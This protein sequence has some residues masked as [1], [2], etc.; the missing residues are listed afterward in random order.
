[1]GRFLQVQAQGLLPG[2]L[3]SEARLHDAPQSQSS[4]E[5]G[6]LAPQPTF[7]LKSKAVRL[8]AS[9]QSA[10]A[11]IRAENTKSE[12]GMAGAVQE[13]PGWSRAPAIPAA[14]L[15]PSPYGLQ[16]DTVCL[17][18]WHRVLC[19]EHCC[20]P[21]S[22]HRRVERATAAKERELRCGS[23]VEGEAWGVLEGVSIIVV[24]QRCSQA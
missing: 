22:S 2:L 3:G 6:R 17:H 19:M 7:V 24:Q 15:H 16:L 23:T 18:S 13:C 21:S 1:M 12:V 9:Q 20:Q 10:E 5:A 8:W 14:R 4:C 11:V